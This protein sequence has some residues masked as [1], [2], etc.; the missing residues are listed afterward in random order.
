M[1]LF[2]SRSEIID[3]IYSTFFDKKKEE[4]TKPEKKRKR[5]NER[6]NLN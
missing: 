2:G 1:K 3:R 4:R 6:E 5:E